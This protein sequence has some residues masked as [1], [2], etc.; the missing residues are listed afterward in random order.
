MT[1]SDK[2][3]ELGRHDDIVLYRWVAGQRRIAGDY[4]MLSDLR[5]A[6]VTSHN[7]TVTFSAAAP[8]VYM[9]KNRTMIQFRDS[10]VLNVTTGDRAGINVLPKFIKRGEDAVEARYCVSM[11]LSEQQQQVPK[12]VERQVLHMSTA[13]AFP[14]AR[15]VV[16]E[17]FRISKKPDSLKPIFNSAFLHAV[18][19]TRADTT[20]DI[21]QKFRNSL[22]KF[23]Y[24]T[25]E[26]YVIS[27]DYIATGGCCVCSSNGITKNSGSAVHMMTRRAFEAELSRKHWVINGKESI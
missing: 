27:N 9:E 7:G 4:I 17:L 21:L 20:E 14:V 15:I 22:G 23:G 11:T 19:A 25:D 6:V 10:G 24:Y 1:L 26:G 2:V 5:L 16:P 13:P 8:I 12:W 3:K 18:G